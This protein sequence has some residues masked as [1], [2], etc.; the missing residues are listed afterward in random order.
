MTP[1]RLIELHCPTC[2]STHWE[3]D[4]DFRDMS[5]EFV[6]YSERQYSCPSC[7][8]THIA[9]TVKQASPPEFLLQPHLLYP[10]KPGE[11]AYWA[12]VLRSQFPDHPLV[13]EIGV[14]L[15]PNWPT[16]RFCLQLVPARWRHLLGR[17]RWRVL[18]WMGARY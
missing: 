13:P 10:M 15:A 3:I 17:I 5:G 7:N 18:K 8:G 6:A 16:A 1:E 11:F 12:S 2:R 9:W 14:T 4:S